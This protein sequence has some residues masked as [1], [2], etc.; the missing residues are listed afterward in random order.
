MIVAQKIESTDADQHSKQI[1]E[2]NDTLGW[3]HRFSLIVRNSIVRDP[4]SRA[5]RYSTD[6]TG[7]K[8][9]S[10]LAN[11]VREILSV[12][13]IGSNFTARLVNAICLRRKYFLYCKAHQ[14]KLAQ[15]YD[16]SQYPEADYREEQDSEFAAPLI[17][18]GFSNL[19][20][21][22]IVP[23]ENMDSAS[24][25]TDVLDR[26][27][28][29]PRHRGSVAPSS[30]ASTATWLGYTGKVEFP[31]APEITDKEE[32]QC[33]YCCLTLEANVFLDDQAWKRHIIKDL[34]PYV[35]THEVC[36]YPDELFSSTREWREHLRR[37]HYSEWICP[38]SSKGNCG[39]KGL[40]EHMNKSSIF[41]TESELH[42]HLTHSHQGQFSP[43]QIEV[44]QRRGFRAVRAVVTCP[45]CRPREPPNEIGETLKPGEDIFKHISEHLLALAL[46]SLPARPQ[47][48]GIGENDQNKS[49]LLKN[50]N[51]HASREAGNNIE[52]WLNSEAKSAAHERLD[53]DQV[54]EL[55]KSWIAQCIGS[56]HKRC[57]GESL[58]PDTA[59]TY[60]TRLIELGEVESDEVKLVIPN[61]NPDMV[62]NYITLGHLTAAEP[63][64]F[65][66]SSTN[67]NRCKDGIPLGNLPPAFRD[68]IK[69]A[70]R[71]GSNVRYIW[72]KSLCV[73][74]DDKKDWESETRKAYQILEG[75]YCHISVV[76]G[77]N[78]NGGFYPRTVAE[79]ILDITP[80]GST[81]PIDVAKPKRI[82]D[83]DSWEQEIEHAQ[84][85]KSVWSLQERLVA[86]RVL[87]FCSDEIAWECRGLEASES[88]PAGIV[89]SDFNRRALRG[90]RT[91]R[92]K[93]LLGTRGEVIH[94][95]EAHENWRHIIAKYSV[96]SLTHPDDKLLAL[97]GIAEA[98]YLRNKVPFIDGIWLNNC[99][100]SQLLWRVEPLWKQERLFYTSTRVTGSLTA[101]TFSWAS[102]NTPEG[103]RQGATLPDKDLLL[104]LSFVWSKGTGNRAQLAVS[105]QKTEVDIW[106]KSRNGYEDM[107]TWTL[108]G[109]RK[110]RAQISNVNVYLDSPKD[111]FERLSSSESSTWLVPAHKNA[112]GDLICLLLSRKNDEVYYTRVGLS[113]IPR[114]ENAEEFRRETQLDAAG[115]FGQLA[116]QEVLI[117]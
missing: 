60:P 68:A 103:I 111:D 61:D 85:N 99:F 12:F 18:T 90:M 113:V 45:F 92:L 51:D 104:K 27:T 94:P 25:I 71:L 40:G 1:Q 10:E 106:L 87:H 76:G 15:R 74:S 116:Y 95:D 63:I 20:H 70:R 64:S 66:L 58:Q 88:A 47:P 93:T 89:D 17:E 13:P 67:M 107:Y 77:N 14:E 53:S 59:I 117:I 41:S 83:Q 43:K 32:H 101:P 73:M 84:L 3:L 57:P 31:P 56:H 49:N 86:P 79:R 24:I 30:G 35:C 5:A 37:P 62:G 102:V 28:S 97:Y 39:S 69:F 112:S 7:T 115:R 9:M 105:C 78:A 75:S 22:V 114:F 42:E 72:I 21:S 54:L 80:I 38:L 100:V 110:N 50:L 65:G 98:F 91:K 8:L 55:A 16:E 29:F 44:L 108:T 11:A 19:G 6:K 4:F 23:P 33:P 52:K 26:Q 81:N 36:P 48:L 109:E 82:V 34:R 2:I 46:I 96:S